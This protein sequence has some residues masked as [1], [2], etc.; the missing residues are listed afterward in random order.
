MLHYFAD[1]CNKNELNVQ[2][3]LSKV[4]ESCTGTNNENGEPQ[5]N[6]DTTMVNTTSLQTNQIDEKVS[7]GN[8]SSVIGRHLNIVT[9]FHAVGVI[10][11][12]LGV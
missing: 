3:D 1:H 11:D 10:P 2:D 12:C 5:H 8:S 9:I 7:P 6:I 4:C